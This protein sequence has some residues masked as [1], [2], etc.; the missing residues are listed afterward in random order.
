MSIRRR[1]LLGGTAALAVGGASLG[2]FLAAAPEHTATDVQ[3]EDAADILFE[4]D[5]LAA[6]EDTRFHDP[7]TVAV[8]T[9]LGGEAA[10]TDDRALNDAVLEYARDERTDW[11]SGDGQTWADGL[12][13]FAV[14]P[15]GRL[16]GTY[17]GEDR[18]VGEGAQLDI[19]G[20][21]KDDF[22]AGRWTEGSVAGV[23]AAADRMG[24]PVIRQ[25]GGT[26]VAVL[27]S[28]LTLAGAGTYV[29]VGMHRVRRC[30]RDRE[31]GDAAMAGV[32]ADHEVTRLHATVL[33]EGSR[34]GGL[35]L[36]RHDDYTRGFREMVE[37]GD[38]VRAIPERELDTRRAVERHTAYAQKATSLDRLD[39]VIADTAAFLNRDSRWVEAWERQVSPVRADLEGVETVL[40]KDLPKQLR[41]L[42]EAQRLR[43][44]ASAEL[45][46]LDRLR[47]ALEG[48]E[49]TPDDALDRLRASRDS[50]S[51]RLDE[52]AAAV[53][54][55]FGDDES[56]RTTMRKA[57]S[58]QRGRRPVEPTILATADPSWMWFSTGAFRS[59][60]S[61]GTSEVEKARSSATSGSTS[62]YSSGGSFSGAGSS[63]R[64]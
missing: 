19:Q 59:G 41:G 17:F 57:M 33:P 60:L 28:L 32:V 51:A 14:D 20:A 2:W 25:T 44:L 43:E 24:A 46:E 48:A 31:A 29:G 9:T 40:T 5:L 7:T 4:P 1:V 8:Y 16:V 34:Y 11:L 18:E 39:D 61:T 12:F 3:V 62:G 10:L 23:R 64:F 53:S 42:P 50:L 22:R 37:L 49:I 47:G 45:V 15:E 38:E 54:R 55:E 52:L 63:S 13:I 6:I 58:S 26:V 36:R 21:A 56:E 27:A 30:R 35:M